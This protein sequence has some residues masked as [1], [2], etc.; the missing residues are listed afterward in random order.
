MHASWEDQHI[1]GHILGSPLSSARHVQIELVVHISSLLLRPFSNPC[2]RVDAGHEMSKMEQIERKRGCKMSIFVLTALSLSRDRSA[3]CMVFANALN[4]KRTS[5]PFLHT[6]KNSEA[7]RKRKVSRE[8][9]FPEH[10]PVPKL[11]FEGLGNFLGRKY[12]SYRQRN[13]TAMVPRPFIEQNN[14]TRTRTERN[15]TNGMGPEQRTSP[16]ATTKRG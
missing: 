14:R 1:F 7:R 3:G 8:R 15:G 2:R 9:T 10:T 11:S 4:E 6:L 12:S 5:K 13:H 16:R